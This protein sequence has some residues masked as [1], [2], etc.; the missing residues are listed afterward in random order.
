[1]LR[2]V[3]YLYDFHV[4]EVWQSEGRDEHGENLVL[5][6]LHVEY[7]RVVDLDLAMEVYWADLC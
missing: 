6:G 4:E 2:Y 3:H 1:M 5:V 7:S